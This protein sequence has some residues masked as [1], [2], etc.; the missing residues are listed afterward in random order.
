MIRSKLLWVVLTFSLLIQTTFATQLPLTAEGAV[1]MEASTGTVLYSK[2]PYY[3]FYP[4][5]T[6]KVLTTLILAESFSPDATITKSQESVDLIPGDSSHIGLNIGDTYTYEAGLYGIIL[7]SDNFI[8]H[9]MAMYHSGSIDAFSKAMNEKAKKLG[10]Y[11]S[12]FVNPH[13]YHDPNHYTTPY[14]LALIARGA[15]DNPLVEKIAGTPNYHL[16]LLNT[17]QVFTFNHSAA[18]LKEN[19][20]FYNAHITAAKTGYH[21]PAGRTLVAKGVYDDIT[22]IAVVM[23]SGKPQYFE[24]INSLLAYGSSHF[25]TIITKN[26]R[27]EVQN[28]SY[29]PWAQTSIERLLA[30]HKFIFTPKLYQDFAT[31]Y[32]FNTLLA[33]CFVLDQSHTSH[34]RSLAHDYLTAPVAQ[35]LLEKISLSYGVI[36]PKDF[37]TSTLTTFRQSTESYLTLQDTIVLTTTYEDWLLSHITPYLYGSPVLFSTGELFFNSSLHNLTTLL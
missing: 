34:Y 10:A 30:Q 27:V 4:A 36:L 17:E 32:E 26:G 37:V 15:F 13:G 3:T 5:S 14:D 28:I 21:T 20:P 1:L 7:G 8:S 35:S 29:S 11:A 23:K 16:Q 31:S 25:K 22:L 24:D 33:N 19:S 18:F 2:N 12:N 6:T 9:D